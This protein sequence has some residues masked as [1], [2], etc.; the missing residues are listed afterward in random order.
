MGCFALE[1]TNTLLNDSLEPGIWQTKNTRLTK[2]FMCYLKERMES[3]TFS[4]L[5][6]MAQKK[7]EAG[8]N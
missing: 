5:D 4:V 1:L 6:F 3:D 8:R 2:A 7:L